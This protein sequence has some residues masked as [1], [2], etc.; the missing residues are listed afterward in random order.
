MALGFDGSGGFGADFYAAYKHIYNPKRVAVLAYSNRP[1]FRDLAKK[2]RFEGDTYNHSVFY[3]D[4]QGG[5]ADFATAIAQ[6]QASSQGARFVLNR[7]REYQAISISNEE[8]RA[9]RSDMGSLLRKKSHE[10]DRVINEM[11][12]RMD[13]ALHGAGTGVVASFTTGGSVTGN[14]ITLDTPQ[15]G[16]RFSVKMYLQV[17]TT[18]NTNGTANTLL[19]SGASVQVKAINRSATSTTLTLDQNLNVAFPSIAT[20]TQYFLLRKGENLG[21]GVTN[22]FGGVS[23]LKSWL[24]ATAPTNGDNFWGFDRSIDAQR[25]SGVRYA[26][27]AGEKMETTFQNASAELFL[28][29]ANPSTCLVAPV[30]FSKYSQELGNKVRYEDAP[31]RGDSGYSSLVIRGQSGDIRL[32]SDPQIDPGTFYML[33]MDTWWVNHLDGL[34]HLDESDG[35]PAA[36]EQNSDAIEI[37]WR[38]WYQLVCDAPGYN[39]VGSFG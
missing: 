35:R 23:G 31:A 5:S 30:D 4:P 28:Q 22:P 32:Q 17:A 18:N 34:P 15:L 16:I 21:F 8:I 27:T 12:R 38:G 39:L 10:T 37:R 33:D 9:S 3:E 20:T 19:N 11:S 25:L 7:G 26:A 14:T 29:G 24:P 36:R 2:D 13:I 6:K 1:L